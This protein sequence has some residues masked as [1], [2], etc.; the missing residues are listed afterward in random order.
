[1]ARLRR[2]NGW[3]DGWMNNPDEKLAEARNLEE[4][5]GKHQMD[6]QTLEELTL[7]LDHDC[8][9][10]EVAPNRLALRPQEMTELIRLL[11]DCRFQSV[12]PS[13]D[14]ER[15]F[16]FR[17][18]LSALALQKAQGVTAFES[19]YYVRLRTQFEDRF[20]ELQ[21]QH[22]WDSSF[23]PKK[24]R[25]VQCSYLLQ[26]CAEYATNFGRAEPAAVTGL[27]P[28]VDVMVAGAPI[29]MVCRRTS[30]LPLSFRLGTDIAGGTI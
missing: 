5:I 1:M 17:G 23:S 10:A 12:H 8:L 22:L 30:L 24:F 26:A 29:A 11:A 15:E 18:L 2:P 3:Y 9:C 4:A 16:Q 13:T 6:S 20:K 25:Q 28:L 27:R 7:I 14:F 19:D 21:W